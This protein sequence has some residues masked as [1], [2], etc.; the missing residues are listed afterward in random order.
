MVLISFLE[1]Q[2]KTMTKGIMFGESLGK[3]FP[4]VSVFI[5][6]IYYDAQDNITLE[7]K[8]TFFSYQTKAAIDI[9]NLSKSIK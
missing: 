7:K 2:S 8:I 3:Q 1:T 9:L 5:L 4:I 6:N